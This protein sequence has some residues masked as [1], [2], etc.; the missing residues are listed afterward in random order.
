MSVVLGVAAAFSLAAGEN[1]V[2]DGAFDAVKD[3]VP[4]SFRCSNADAE[5]GRFELF[6][7]DLTWNKCGKLV[8]GQVKTG[9]SQGMPVDVSSALVT[10]GGTKERPGM[11]VEPGTDYAYSFFRRTPCSRQRTAPPTVRRRRCSSR[12]AAAP[13]RRD[14]VA[15]RVPLWSGCRTAPCRGTP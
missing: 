10:I 4:V 7:E 9:Y 3:A 12:R 13:E 14:E 1:L 2:A 8:A 11:P 5:E 6:T 15:S